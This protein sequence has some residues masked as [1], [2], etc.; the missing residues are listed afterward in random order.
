MAGTLGLLLGACAEASVDTEEPKPI[1]TK[2]VQEEESAL[3]LGAT[4]TGRVEKPALGAEQR[5]V[6]LT[7]LPGDATVEVDGQLAK[8]RNGVIE[9][10]GRVGET[11][12]LRVSS[13]LLSAKEQRI[14]G[15]EVVIRETGASPSLIDLN[16]APAQGPAGGSEKQIPFPFDD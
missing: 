11:R 12:K 8:R 7:V 4:G 13:S 6:T 5:R 1:S 10:M 14:Q 3:G 16:D 15:R 2:V 9:L